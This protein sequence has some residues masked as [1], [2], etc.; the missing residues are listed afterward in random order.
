VQQ[1]LQQD[2]ASRQPDVDAISIKTK[3]LEIGES[4]M[5]AQSEELMNRYKSVRA[6]VKVGPSIQNPDC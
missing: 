6:K 1:A 4:K 3:H 5:A 2:V